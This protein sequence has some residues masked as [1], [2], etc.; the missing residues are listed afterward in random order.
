M[1]SYLHYNFKELHIYRYE[2]NNFMSIAGELAHAYKK[3]ESCVWAGQSLED[4]WLLFGL[5]S[6][7]SKLANKLLNTQ[8]QFGGFIG[9]CGF[10]ELK[11]ISL[12]VTYQDNTVEQLALAEI[13]DV[14]QC[15][16]EFECNNE[17]E[18]LKDL[19]VLYK[20]DFTAAETIVVVP[21]FEPDLGFL[22]DQIES[23]KQQSYASWHCLILDDASNVN[24]EAALQRLVGHDHRFT[25]LKN[26]KNLGFYLNIERALILID[27]GFFGKSINYISLADQD[28]YWYSEKLKKSVEF[29][30]VNP[31]KSLVFCD[32]EI[33]DE[34]LQLMQHSFWINRSMNILDIDKLMLKNCVTGAATVFK[35]NLLQKVIP[36]PRSIGKMYH[37][38]WIGVVAQSHDELAFLP[39]SLY[40]YRQHD[41]QDT[42]FG[43]FNHSMVTKVNNSLERTQKIINN[44]YYISIDKLTYEIL[45]SD[46]IRIAIMARVILT[47]FT[48]ISEDKK[49]LLTKLS[50]KRPKELFEYLRSEVEN[51]LSDGID[52]STM[53]E[54]A[55][56]LASSML[57]I[58]GDGSWRKIRV[59][60]MEIDS[61]EP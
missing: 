53:G 10:S 18:I 14:L 50:V 30:N 51:Y 61:I 16:K 59:A 39:E 37:D 43:D 48:T 26:K 4:S 45:S 60:S 35:Y 15:V 19:Q 2:G 8:A 24:C 36:F 17:I 34:D 3:I 1:N 20:G 32:Q 11:S 27:S 23:I 28:D 25:V 49:E 58:L 56:I 47:R 5:E 31:E 55:Y 22:L 6:S 42:G 44:G 40:A 38:H 57:T 9:L 33:V 46:I 21:T 29:L 12:E 41:A 52:T 7:D 54:E 13:E